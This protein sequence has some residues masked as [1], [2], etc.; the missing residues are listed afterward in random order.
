MMTIMTMPLT[1]IMMLMMPR[2]RRCGVHVEIFS[3]RHKL[4][5]VP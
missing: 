1:M 3:V 4:A 2:S 5:S